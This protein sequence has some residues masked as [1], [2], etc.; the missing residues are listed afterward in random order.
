M[1]LM[2][3]FHLSP[4]AFCLLC[5]FCLTI[6]HPTKIT[7]YNINIT[8]FKILNNNEL[9]DIC[10]DLFIINKHTNILIIH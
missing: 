9:I 7:L 8:N 3:I 10:G 2:G 6:Q 5:N 4:S 1:T